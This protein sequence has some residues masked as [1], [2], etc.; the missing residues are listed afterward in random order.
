MQNLPRKQWSPNLTLKDALDVSIDASIRARQKN[1]IGSL[2]PRLFFAYVVDKS[3]DL[4]FFQSFSSLFKFS[5]KD[6]PY[7]DRSR[8]MVLRLLSVAVKAHFF[9]YDRERVL[10]EPYFLATP[11]VSAAGSVFFTLIYE[12][13][14]HTIIVSE[15]ELKSLAP[16]RY[17][18]VDE[19][20][21]K[22]LVTD[23]DFEFPTVVGVDSFKWFHYKKWY[24]LKDEIKHSFPDAKKSSMASELKKMKTKEELE[25]KSFILMVPYILKDEMMKVGCIWHPTLK[26]WCLPKGYDIELVHQYLNVLKAKLNI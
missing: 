18:K 10:H 7:L 15:R 5:Q 12:V 26:L 21:K 25:Q 20:Y 9:L 3:P 17:E 6:T 14:S 24:M 11:D 1:I 16:V 4:N 13:E 8:D 2:P 22:E 23:I 19:N